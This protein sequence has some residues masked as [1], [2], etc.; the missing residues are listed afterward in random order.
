MNLNFHISVENE[1][2]AL[3]AELA[4]NEASHQTRW[5]ALLNNNPIKFASNITW[6]QNITAVPE[7]ELNT[8]P[9]V[10]I[11][12]LWGTICADSVNEYAYRVFCSFA[13]IGYVP[14]NAPG[15]KHH[16]HTQKKYGLYPVLLNN[17]QCEESS[18]S[19]QKCTSGP[20]G[21]Q[22]CPS[23]SDFQ[24]FCGPGITLGVEPVFP[25]FTISPTEIHMERT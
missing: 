13:G 4:S 10:N 19:F 7:S 18:Y 12:G 6:A 2:A 21:I 24:A 17:V 8:I 1:I 3:R 23:Q 5:T 16:E 20:M 11:G 9:I 22:H 14:I 25:E 15:A